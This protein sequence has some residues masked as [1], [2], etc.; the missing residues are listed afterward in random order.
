MF[1]PLF[2]RL[3]KQP[4]LSSIVLFPVPEAA[5]R[6]LSQ[7]TELF[8]WKIKPVARHGTINRTNRAS[9]KV[10]A[11]QSVHENRITSH[12]TSIALHVETNTIVLR[13][14]TKII[15]PAIK[16]FT[17]KKGHTETATGPN[18]TR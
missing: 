2:S 11:R 8:H 16:Q 18:L 15:T 5:Q 12:S 13:I 7:S 9:T 4:I 17:T 1:R 6:P 14:R 10:K 3:P